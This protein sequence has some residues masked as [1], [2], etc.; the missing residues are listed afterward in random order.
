MENETN[1]AA[2]GVTAPD[3][4]VA[5]GKP[6]YRLKLDHDS[7][8]WG[9]ELFDPSWAVADGDVILDHAPDNP[10]GRYKWSVERQRLEA[11]E[12]K[13][14]RQAEG[15]ITSDRAFYE[16]LRT[17][18]ECGITPSPVALKWAGEYEKTVDMD[19]GRLSSY[20]RKLQGIAQ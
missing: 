20:F 17:L 5:A 7:V 12:P 10:P 18:H 8:Y 9:A 2:A 1:A 15:E 14:V 4:A 16:T 19:E 11:L 13:L 3:A 6:I